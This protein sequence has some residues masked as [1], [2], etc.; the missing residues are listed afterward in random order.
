MV[1]IYSDGKKSTLT[2]IAYLKSFNAPSV[3]FS[4]RLLIVF[5]LF[6]TMEWN[7]LLPWYKCMLLLPLN[8]SQLFCI[9]LFYQCMSTL[10]TFSPYWI[11]ITCSCI[12]FAGMTSSTI[13]LVIVSLFDESFFCYYMNQIINLIIIDS[14]VQNLLAVQECFLDFIS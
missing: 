3:P 9:W 14:F 8:C 13:H 4:Y 12:W 7:T 11:W 2:S 6:L 5:H 10:Q 1:N